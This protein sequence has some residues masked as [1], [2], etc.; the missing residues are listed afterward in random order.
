[1]QP[2]AQT[3]YLVYLL[4]WDNFTVTYFKHVPP[5]GLGEIKL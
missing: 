2:G 5:L 4:V 1:M 3:V